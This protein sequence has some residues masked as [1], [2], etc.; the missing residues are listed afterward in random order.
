MAWP[1]AIG[2]RKKYKK[3]GSL[4]EN[5]NHFWA[6]CHPQCAPKKLP[7]STTR[8]RRPP[9]G[10]HAWI[11][12]E[13]FSYLSQ[14]SSCGS[15]S[16]LL[17]NFHFPLAI[18]LP[19]RP[20]SAVWCP[21][22]KVWSMVSS[23]AIFRNAAFSLLARK[24]ALA[25]SPTPFRPFFSFPGVSLE[26]SKQRLIANCLNYSWLRQEQHHLISSEYFTPAKS[27][28]RWMAS[29]HCLPPVRS[30]TGPKINWPAG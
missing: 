6:T 4:P 30:H 11:L 21:L 19:R 17:F 26:D 7:F 15:S 2:R 25:L 24:W 23:V 1:K 12:S 13:P 14:Y 16:P 9:F 20:V 18:R 27:I 28:H 5:E 22:S 3:S 8:R 29:T 10:I